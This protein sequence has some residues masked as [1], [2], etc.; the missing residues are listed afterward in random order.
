MKKGKTIAKYTV[1]GILL[2][3]MVFSMFAVLISAVQSV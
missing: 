1:I 3:S 2:F